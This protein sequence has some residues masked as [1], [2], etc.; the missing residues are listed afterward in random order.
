M[1]SRLETRCIASSLMSGHS[2]RDMVIVTLS[3][4][5]TPSMKYRSMSC[6]G[7][8]LSSTSLPHPSR[9]FLTRGRLAAEYG[10]EL[11]YREDFHN[12]FLD[13][14]R[15]AEFANLLT[16]MRV[17]DEKGDAEMSDSQWEAASPSYF[18]AG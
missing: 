10:L 11:E 9:E 8:S 17:V 16:R 4:S 7:T 6:T 18:S 14:G 2:P 13:E 12:V 3:S 5:R 15:N 1:N